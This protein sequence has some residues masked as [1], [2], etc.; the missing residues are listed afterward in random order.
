M[1]TQKRLKQLYHYE[2]AT[3]IFT[4]IN[5]RGRMKAGS[6]AGSYNAS[7]GYI[8]MKIDHKMYKA[9]RLAYLYMTGSIPPEVDH[10]NRNCIDN[11]W[12]NLNAATHS[13]NQRNQ[14]VPSNNTSGTMGVGWH[15]QSQRWRAGINVLSGRKHLGNFKCKTAAILARKAAEIAHNFHPNHGV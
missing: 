12:N 2:P 4:F 7:T 6:V 14:S 9:H 11:S 10:D 8:N 1:L 5:T 3:G 13:S 15:K